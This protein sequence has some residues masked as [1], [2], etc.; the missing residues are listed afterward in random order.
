MATLAF[1]AVAALASIIGAGIAFFNR[2]DTSLSELPE[3]STSIDWREESYYLKFSVEPW[4]NLPTGGTGVFSGSRKLYHWRI[5]SIE[6]KRSGLRRR[7]WLSRPMGDHVTTWS[8]S[9]SFRSPRVGGEIQ[10][11]PDCSEAELLFIC[12]KSSLK[13]TVKFNYVRDDDD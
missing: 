4:I 11:H 9:I 10:I 2:R 7:K 1:A 3:I 12:K 6:I 5:A 8:T 13:R